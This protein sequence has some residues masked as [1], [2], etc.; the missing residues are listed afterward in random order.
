MAHAAQGFTR[1]EAAAETSRA[2]LARRTSLLLRREVGSVA[3]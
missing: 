2:E 3:T 1:P